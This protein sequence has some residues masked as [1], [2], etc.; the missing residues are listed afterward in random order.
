MSLCGISILW[1]KIARSICNSTEAVAQVAQ[2]SGR[3]VLFFEAQTKEEKRSLKGIS[4]PLLKDSEGIQLTTLGNPPSIL[5][6]LLRIILETL[7]RRDLINCLSLFLP[8]YHAK[9]L[10]EA[11]RINSKYTLCVLS[12]QIPPFLLS[13][14]TLPVDHRT[15]SPRAGHHRLTAPYIR[16]KEK[17]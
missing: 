12:H 1:R 2:S 6:F 16:L 14:Q 15:L 13:W 10:V 17:S 3:V 9:I 4:S 5:C 8:W 7:K 11:F